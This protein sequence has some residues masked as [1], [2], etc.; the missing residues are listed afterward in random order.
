MQDLFTVMIS[1]FAALV[2]LLY[3]YYWK[4]ARKEVSQAAVYLNRCA[5]H[6][7]CGKRMLEIISLVLLFVWHK[8]GG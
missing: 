1:G 4:C 3:V 5:Q 2:I 8:Y 7:V 6:P